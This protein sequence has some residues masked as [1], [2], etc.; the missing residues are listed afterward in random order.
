M[1]RTDDEQVGTPANHHVDQGEEG[2]PQEQD[3]ERERAAAAQL[4]QRRYR[5]YR[6]RRQLNGFGL[7]SSSRWAEVRRTGLFSFFFFFESF[8]EGRERLLTGTGR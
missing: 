5:G 2:M 7:D 8:F 6:E 1:S 3:R 4:I